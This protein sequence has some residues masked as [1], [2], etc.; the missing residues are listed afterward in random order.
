V[1]APVLALLA[2]LAFGVA[3]FMGG[4]ASRRLPLPVVLALSQAVGLAAI[5][6]VVLVRGQ[7]PPSARFALYALGAAVLGTIVIATLYRALAIGSMSVVAPI[8]GTAAV[9][10][11]V[12]GFLIGES[13]TTPQNAGIVLALVGVI[14]AS[15]TRHEGGRATVGAGVWLAVVAAIVIGFFL[16]ALNA[17]SE[18][19]P[20][21]ATLTARA[22]TVSFLWISVAVLRPSLRIVGRDRLM[23]PLVGVLDVT[24]NLLFAIATTKGLIGVVSVLGSLYPVV[25]VALAR[26]LHHERLSRLQAAGVVAAF[27]GVGLIAAG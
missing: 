15:R 4:S 2:A 22:A 25:T 9:I 26:A 18:A 13:P 14:L 23:L 24:G 11:V 5:V 12:A 16:V 19:D 7:G 3:D 10:P 1:L 8:A 17:A 21:W 6:L 20:Y 27:A